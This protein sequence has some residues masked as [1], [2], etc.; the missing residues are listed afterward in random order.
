MKEWARQQIAEKQRLEAAQT[1]HAQE[2]ARLKAENERIKAQAEA[3]KVKAEQEK[4]Q[5]A[6]VAWVEARQKEISAKLTEAYAPYKQAILESCHIEGKAFF[7]YVDEVSLDGKILY[8]SPFI[9]WE[10][11]DGSGGVIHLRCGQ[12]I[13]STDFVYANILEKKDLSRQEIDRARIEIRPR[14]QIPASNTSS[15]WAPSSETVNEGY[16]AAIKVT[17][18]AVGAAILNIMSGN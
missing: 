11:A 3:D 10:N 6:A 12:N 16:Q 4:H 15:V 17:A 7:Y 2:V 5:A 13:E 1:S 18:A 8:F 14:S 9:L